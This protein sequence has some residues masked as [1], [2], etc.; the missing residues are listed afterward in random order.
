MTAL[1][2]IEEIGTVKDRVE[3]N[4]TVKGATI[5]FQ[6]F[7]SKQPCSDDLMRDIL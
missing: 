4:G 1:I 6:K 3:E 2:S 5:G 7:S